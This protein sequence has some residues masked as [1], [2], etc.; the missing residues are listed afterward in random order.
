MNKEKL[1]EINELLKNLSEDEL[2]FVLACL[3]SRY[4]FSEVYMLGEMLYKERNS[5]HE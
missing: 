2:K 3:L 1:H 5:T 4:S